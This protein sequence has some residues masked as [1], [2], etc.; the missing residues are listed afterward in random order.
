MEGR[1]VAKALRERSVV[2]LRRVE[3]CKPQN[4]GVPRPFPG[5]FA[6]L[7]L[8]A[9]SLGS[10]FLLSCCYGGITAMVLGAIELS[11][12]PAAGGGI[13]PPPTVRGLSATPLG[14]PDR[15]LIEFQLHNNDAGRL[16]VKID[17]L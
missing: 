12:S 13:D 17:L 2:K 14:C 6:S 9:V 15:I 16:D 1:S 3:P 10:M 8:I 5:L 7:Q 11:K 4:W